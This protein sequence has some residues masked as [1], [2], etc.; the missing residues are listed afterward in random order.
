MKR[1]YI[2]NPREMKRIIYRKIVKG[3]EIEKS[4]L[5]FTNIMKLPYRN[6][7]K[8]GINIKCFLTPL[9]VKTSKNINSIKPPIPVRK[10][11]LIF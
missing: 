11:N 10:Y 3:K 9:N 2:S 7:T 8:E 5:L 6:R 1:E 4:L